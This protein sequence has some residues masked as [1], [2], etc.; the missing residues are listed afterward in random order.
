[1][2]INTKKICII[3]SFLILTT[4]VGCSGEEQEIPQTPTTTPTTED[5]IISENTTETPNSDHYPVTIMTPNLKGELVEMVFDKAPERV[6][7]AYQGT[8]ETM[9]ALG[10]EN[11]VIASFGLDE[12]VKPEFEAGFANINYDDSIFTPDLETII[13]LQPD[14][15]FAWGSIFGETRLNDITTWQDRDVNCLVSANTNSYYKPYN[16]ENEYQ[17]ILDIGKI[18]NVEEKAETLVNEMKSKIEITLEKS[19]NLEKPTVLAI[20]FLEGQIRNYSSD[21]IIGNMIEELGGELLLTES[22]NFSKEDLITANPD[23]IFVINVL[24]LEESGANEIIEDTALASLNSVT[25]ERV[26]DVMLGD[27]YASAVRTIDGINT[28]VNA[29]YPELN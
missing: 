27:V 28:I 17:T 2:K 12:P 10:L 18:F 24:S 9:I 11:H 5:N 15:I 23:I 22:E 16:I 3:M 6:V 25:N 1:M 21:T 26:Y 14:F 8:I 20:E 19:Q 13:S 29:L 4:F 7:L